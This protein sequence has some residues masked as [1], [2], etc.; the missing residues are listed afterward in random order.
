MTLALVASDILF[1]LD[2]LGSVSAHQ[3]LMVEGDRLGFENRYAQWVRRPL[4]GDGRK[5]IKDAIEKTFAICEE[6]L[7]SYQCNMY[8]GQETL[9]HEQKMIVN[10]ISNTLKSI[11]SRKQRV[12]DGLETLSTFERYNQ[13][14]EFKIQ[15]S[16]FSDR[17]LRICE[18]A[19][20]I[21]LEIH[22]KHDVIVREQDLP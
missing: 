22:P 15:M 19:E 14:P 11:I 8:I 4:S 18:W 2:I 13:D 16:R 5:Q 9:Q 12:L 6:L 10:N 1:N 17:M 7:H 21:L 20:K 3:T